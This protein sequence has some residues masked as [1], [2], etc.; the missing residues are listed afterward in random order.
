MLSKPIAKQ[1][2]SNLCPQSGILCT[3]SRLIFSHSD[4]EL[5]KCLWLEQVRKVCAQSALLL[6]FHRDFLCEAVL[7]PSGHQAPI[8]CTL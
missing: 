5:E 8:L 4:I 3:P 6:W 2:K 1:R 7:G